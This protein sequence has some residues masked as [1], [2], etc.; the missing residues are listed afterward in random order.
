MNKLPFTVRME[1]R[2]DE[3]VDVTELTQAAQ[4]AIARFPYFSVRVGLDESQSYA[5]EHNDEPLAVLPEKDERLVLGSDEVNG[6]LFAI[7]YQGDT[8]WS[9]F[10]MRCA[11]RTARSFG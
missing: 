2:L 9:T 1:I 4:E 10:P 5:L 8:V 7:T 11:V 3:P 6:H